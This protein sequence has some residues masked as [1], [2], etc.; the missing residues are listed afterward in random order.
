MR[1]QLKK[2]IAATA[3]GAIL[4]PIV[5]A[6]G[7]QPTAEAPTPAPEATT[8]PA[9]PGVQGSPAPGTQANAGNVTDLIRNN[10]SLSTLSSVINE[11]DLSNTLGQGGPYTVFAPS[12][13]AFAALPAETRERLLREENR[14]LLRQIL[15]YHVVPGSLT[16][17]QLQPGQV[18]TQAGNSVN[19]QV[20]GQQ[21]RVNEARVIQ[22]DLQAANG[23]VHI[24]DRIIL[25]PNVN[26]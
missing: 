9:S 15:T 3:L 18:Q 10:P 13:Q 14:Q 2:T 6:C 26:L 17:S 21:V 20:D 25:P 4:M 16:A 8:A 19:V 11:A 5:A 24:V 23:V 12:D 7:G 1:Q 22:P